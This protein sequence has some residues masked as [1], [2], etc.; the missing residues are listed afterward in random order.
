ME[1]NKKKT[2]YE[3]LNI[4]GAAIFCALTLTQTILSIRWLVGN[5]MIFEN[6]KYVLAY[7]ECAA[8]LILAAAIL[9]LIKNITDK[10]MKRKIKIIYCIVVTV[11]ILTLPLVISA[12]FFATLYTL[13]FSLLLFLTVFAI[14]YFYGNH[15]HRL[16]QLIGILVILILLS[17]LNRA[18]F[19]CA[20]TETF[21][22]L[23]IQLIRNIGIRKR[24]MAD[25]SWRNTL[26]LFC[27]L[28]I[29]ML[30]PQ[31][32][33]YNNINH[34]MYH[35]SIEEQI[36]ARVLV[37]YIE[38]EKS[39]NEEYLLGVIRNADY[40]HGHP[41]RNFLNIINRY[42]EDELDMDTIWKNLYTNA[43]HR[44]KKNI[45]R[46]YLRDVSMAL[47][48]PFDVQYLMKTDKYPSHYGFYY[49]LFEEKLPEFS[50]DHFR[51]SMTA[52]GVV[53]SVEVIQVLMA[54]IID[55]KRKKFKLKM[56]EG[57]HTK[58]EAVTLLLCHGML[59]ILLQTLFSIEGA[60]FVAGFGS[61][62]VWIVSAS[63]LWFKQGKKD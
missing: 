5:I 44:Y 14:R 13:C 24:N 12:C 62:I 52:L 35:N 27:I 4:T 18:T 34:T 16:F 41:Y 10:V 25:K 61:I 7:K 22:F 40:S 49:G 37:P 63:F 6:G 55:I 36:S 53:S 30:M 21:V 57:R 60:S 11:Y 15:E 3:Y 28:I 58:I 59:W 48:S 54:L 56:E 29:I 31:Y 38:Y 20:V 8:F 2:F 50:D 43:F 45:V 23:T 51:F 33:S 9:I 47:V 26:L 32:F 1:E 46:R 42:E 17:Y 39:E 19:W